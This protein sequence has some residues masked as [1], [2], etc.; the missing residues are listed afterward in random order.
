L[1][2]FTPAVNQTG[3]FVGHGGDGFGGAKAGSQASIGGPQRPW[4]GG[5]RSSGNLLRRHVWPGRVR[6]PGPRGS[7][8]GRHAADVTDDIGEVDVH[9]GA[10]LLPVLDAGG[11]GADEGVALAPVGPSYPEVIGGTAR[12][13]E[14][15]E[16]VEFLQPL[17]VSELGF[18]AG[19]VLGVAGLDQGDGTTPRF[20]NVEEGDPVHSRACHDHC[21]DVASL[22]PVG[23]GMKVGRKARKPAHG[24]WRAIRRHG[25]VGLGTAHVD[26]GGIEIQRR[27]SSGRIRGLLG[28]SMVCAGFGPRRPLGVRRV[29]GKGAVRPGCGPG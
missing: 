28:F 15:P 10:S 26:P 13:V 6:R 17:A 25:D 8:P 5:W 21:L 19:H 29:R 27:S 20:Q 24:L 23:H 1:A 9:C 7:W 3:E 22:E 11:R 4:C 2:K 16:G 12:A 14:Q 18:A